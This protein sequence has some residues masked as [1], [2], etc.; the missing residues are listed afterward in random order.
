VTGYRAIAA[1]DLTILQRSR[2]SMEYNRMKLSW[3]TILNWAL[4]MGAT[5]ARNATHAQRDFPRTGANPV[6]QHPLIGHPDAIFAMTY[7]M[8]ASGFGVPGISILLCCEALRLDP[9]GPLARSYALRLLYLSLPERLHV[10][11]IGKL[12][13]WTAFDP[14]FRTVA[15]YGGGWEIEVWDLSTTRKITTIDCDPEHRSERPAGVGVF[16]T[17]GRQLTVDVVRPVDPKYPNGYA[18]LET[19][20][21]DACKGEL[22]SSAGK[23]ASLPTLKRLA[24]P[25]SSLPE[26]AASKDIRWRTSDNKIV[27]VDHDVWK[28]EAN[29]YVRAQSLA[30]EG[31]STFG[32]LSVEFGTIV[33]SDVLVARYGNGLIRVRDS[34]GRSDVAAP[35]VGTEMASAVLLGDDDRRNIDTPVTWI[36]GKQ[37]IAL[38]DGHGQI[39]LHRVRLPNRSYVRG[40]A[41]S[42]SQVTATLARDL[43]HAVVV[44]SYDPRSGSRRAILTDGI[45]KAA[46]ASGQVRQI[47]E[48]DIK[49]N[50]AVVTVFSSD[51]NQLLIQ[52]SEEK[53]CALTLLDVGTGRILARQEGV[54]DVIVP[55]RWGGSAVHT[56]FQELQTARCLLPISGHRVLAAVLRR[57]AAFDP[58]TGLTNERSWEIR[59]I[60]LASGASQAVA[61]APAGFPDWFVSFSYDGRHCLAWDRQSFDQY[62]RER[63]L[64]IGVALILAVDGG[65]GPTARLELTSAFPHRLLKQ[66]FPTLQ[67]VRATPQGFAADLGS[68]AGIEATPHGVDLIRDTSSTPLVDPELRFPVRADAL[69]RTIADADPVDAFAPCDQIVLGLSPD[70]V[71]MVTAALT[72]RQDAGWLRIWN[73]ISN[74]PVSEWLWLDS[75]PAALMFSPQS[76]RFVVVSTTGTLTSWPLR[77]QQDQDHGWLKQIG[78]ALCGRELDGLRAQPLS[79]QAVIT[80][81]AELLAALKDRPGITNETR[82]LLEDRLGFSED[83]AAS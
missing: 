5:K 59:R 36:Q 28:L 66:I 26:E 19:K 48:V 55:R 1:A 63:P 78:A 30:P 70:G 53:T 23:S 46:M 20:V 69:L 81:R 39:S 42:F 25:G 64:G 34:L 15:V 38:S 37:G 33:G 14:A 54:A 67:N 60:D 32:P 56:Q 41:Q 17:D 27:I 11:D 29:G 3:R 65:G 16:S 51:G 40:A 83:L 61:L 7:A 76:D 73:A 49:N 10:I 74:A 71:H 2:A 58:G 77:V 43:S 4:A 79:A 24:P 47:A 6:Q 50:S 62:G 45:D 22:V 31:R 18:T 12:V 13:R 72:G 44:T 21:W 68:N 9:D 57:D 82:A 75:Q 52:E 80:A 8:P 35:F